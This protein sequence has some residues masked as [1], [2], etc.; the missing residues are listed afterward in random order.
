ME[1]R[2]YAADFKNVMHVICRSKLHHNAAFMQIP[3]GLENEHT[4]IIDLI[5]RKAFY[6]EEP[7]G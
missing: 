2:L 4:G 3:I 5:R 6:F 1:F 7:Q